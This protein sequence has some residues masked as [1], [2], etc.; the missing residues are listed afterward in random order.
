MVRIG[1]CSRVVC[2]VYSS[3]YCSHSTCNVAIVLG[4]MP[5]HTELDGYP[6][7]DHMHMMRGVC[8]SWAHFLSPCLVT[9]RLGQ[10][11]PFR[12]HSVG[13]FTDLDRSCL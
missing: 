10:N 8:D 2:Y 3:L 9:V 6:D 11:P 13:G 12:R 7:N 5:F 1:T 4:I